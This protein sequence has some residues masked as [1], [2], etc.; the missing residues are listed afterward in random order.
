MAIGFGFG[1]GLGSGGCASSFDIWPDAYFPDDPQGQGFCRRASPER[2]PTPG[3]MGRCFLFARGT[4][5][6]LRARL[7]AEPRLVE[8][9]AE[10]AAPDDLDAM[11]AIGAFTIYGGGGQRVGLDIYRMGIIPSGT[12][13]SF[14]WSPVPLR[15]PIDVAI[16]AGWYVEVESN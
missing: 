2:A 6:H 14:V 12:S 5:D 13:E 10:T 9:H 15:D 1:L 16:G 4:I 3:E 11:R 7:A 8:I